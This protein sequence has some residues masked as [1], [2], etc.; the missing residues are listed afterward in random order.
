MKIKSFTINHLKLNKGIYISNKND[1]ITTLD[2]RIRTPY[3]STV[4]TTVE[5]H[6]LEHLFATTL[7]SGK[8]KNCVI[9]CG[10]MGCATGFYVLFRNLNDKD[11]L[12][13][14]KISL[15]AVI[16]LSTMP[17]D[18]KIECGDNRTLSLE[19]G[20]TIAVEYLQLIK[21]K[22]EFDSYPV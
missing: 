1:D 22:L 21:D 7:R 19:K 12:E 18:N 2:L 17:G 16:V 10:P 11:M 15:A 5:I 6:S 9:Y 13:Y 20:K 4:L 14:I 8:H 3:K